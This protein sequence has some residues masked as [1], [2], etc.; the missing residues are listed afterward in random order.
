MKPK[1]VV[2][3]TGGRKFND[4]WAV[5]RAMVK[6]D[7]KYDVTW[8]MGGA[9]G[10]DALAQLWCERVGAAH[11]VYSADWEKYG[12]AAGFVRNQQMVDEGKPQLLIAFP[13]G[14][15]TRDMMNRCLTAGIPIKQ[16]AAKVTNDSPQGFKE[17]VV[18]SAAGTVQH[19]AGNSA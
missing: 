1:I 3:I 10:A 16:I 7:S 12:N 6:V 18:E 8:V 2:A 15:G 17:S 19:L 14:N 9:K 13:G 11:H 5:Q 4:F